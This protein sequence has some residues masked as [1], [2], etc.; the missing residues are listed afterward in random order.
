MTPYFCRARRG[1]KSQAGC[2]GAAQR[3]RF[4]AGPP[5]GLW[6]AER[7]FE[8]RETL[9]DFSPLRL[10]LCRRLTYSAHQAPGCFSV[11]WSDMHP[12]RMSPPVPMSLASTSALAG[13][14]GGPSFYICETQFDPP[15]GTQRLTRPAGLDREELRDRH[16]SQ[17]MFGF[18]KRLPARC[19]VTAAWIALAPRSQEIRVI[20]A[21][22]CR[23]ITP[24]SPLRVLGSWSC[25]RGWLAGW[26]ND[27][28]FPGPGMEQRPRQQQPSVSGL[29]VTEWSAS[30]PCF[31][32]HCSCRPL[33]PWSYPSPPPGCPTV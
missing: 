8:S 14:G 1:V 13:S 17:I 31:L 24:F 16:A 4:P 22:A 20:L 27:V 29:A 15:F 23:P 33:P 25:R 19:H 10:G 32:Q 26:L 30:L 12:C 7:A 21:S 9:N 3:L 6:P 5:I 11:F 28:S 18:Q 2:P